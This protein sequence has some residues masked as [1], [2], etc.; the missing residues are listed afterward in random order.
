MLMMPALLSAQ[1]DITRYQAGAIPVVDG[2]VVF[3]KEVTVPGLTQ[4]QLYDKLL[5][6]AEE[7]FNTDKNRVAYADKEKGD[8]AIMGV[9]RLVFSSTA[10][11]L[12]TSE[13]S[14]RIIINCEGN[15]CHIR[16]TNM[17]YSYNVS[18]QREPERY[19]AEEIITDKYALTKKN[20]LNRL[21]GKFRRKT[22][23]FL[24]S[25]FK[26]ID[27]VLGNMVIANAPLTVTH[28][29]PQHTE[30][31]VVKMQEPTSPPVAKSSHEGYIAFDI[32]KVPQAIM[33]MLPESD[34]IITPGKEKTPVETSATWK[35]LSTMFGKEV[36]SVALSQESTV[37]KQIKDVFTI[38]F[39]NEEDANTP[40][41]IIECNKQGETTD[42]AEKTI[43]GE[44]LQ[45]WIK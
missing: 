2:K 41:M 21:Y 13:M 36:A 1:E 15:V 8:I 34:M 20:Q 11:S 24:D 25:L 45:I 23:D 44:V 31:V 40:W 33:L 43:L 19:L 38:S 4:N 7:R 28:A 26:E 14:Y 29:Y 17:S 3:E 6:W 16:M 35:G 18:Y 39:V 27:G 30:P 22:I 12:D 9:E 10:L 37:Y 5:T 32:D 42:G